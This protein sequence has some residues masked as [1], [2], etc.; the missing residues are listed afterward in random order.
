MHDTQIIRVNRILLLVLSGLLLGVYFTYGHTPLISR[1]ARHQVEGKQVV[2]RCIT[3]HDPAAHKTIRGHK[4]STESCTTCHNGMGRGITRE[5]AHADARTTGGSP[6]GLFSLNMISSGCLRCHPPQTLPVNSPAFQ[7][8]QLFIGKGCGSCHQI[9]GISAGVKGPDLSR[10]G[11]HLSLETL[12]AKI[13]APQFPG[14]YSIMPVFRLSP[15]EFR[16]IAAFLK[17]Q[18]MPHLRP[19]ADTGQSVDPANP[20]ERYNCVSCH[21]FRGRDGMVGP[22]LDGTYAQRDEKWLKRFLKEVS[23]QRPSSRMPE[24]TDE[25][26]IQ[27]VTAALL[28]PGRKHPLSAAPAEQ[29]EKYCARCHGKSGEGNG[30]IAQNLITSPRRFA[31]NPGWFR[32]MPEK[33]LAESVANGVDGTSMPPFVKLLSKEERGLLLDFIRTRFAQLSPDAQPLSDMTVP[34]QSSAN[35]DIRMAYL[36]LCANCHGER[37]DK[38]IRFVHAKQPQ[39]RN[40]RNIVYMDS[41]S[42]EQLYRAIARGIPGTR[43]KAYQAAVPGSGVKTKFGLS[44]GEIWQFV[45]QV[46]RISRNAD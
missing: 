19:P 11:D 9:R 8:W 38:S 2:E 35:V 1:E 46:R 12:E 10:V 45:K 6:D 32:L 34:A 21:N 18:S 22:D 29:Y 15:A 4:P 20:L 42:D 37:G 33:R 25:R 3:C 24:L 28:T 7:G 5:S 16:N 31:D 27:E 43:M 30:P 39:P 13:K 26:G 14:Y 40:F 36:K 23:F 44:D 17:G 41:R